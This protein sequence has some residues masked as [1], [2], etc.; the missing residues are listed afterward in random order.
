M[1]TPLQLPTADSYSCLSS[2]SI[3][4]GSDMREKFEG[5]VTVTCFPCA[6]I[7]SEADVAIIIDSSRFIVVVFC[8]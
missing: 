1:V 4:M 2:I 7:V 6:T 8:I 5:L 3:T